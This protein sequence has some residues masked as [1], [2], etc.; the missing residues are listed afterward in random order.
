[1]NTK[2][3]LTWRWR[4]MVR[5][6]QE[7]PA[8]VDA[9]LVVGPA[10]LA[11]LSVGLVSAVVSSTLLS[12][13]SFGMVAAL[14]LRRSRPVLS[15]VVVFGLAFVH[16]VAGARLLPAD[17]AVLVALYS[18]A[19]HAPRWARQ[20]S[21]GAGLVGAALQGLNVVLNRAVSGDQAT[22]SL[23]GSVISIVIGIAALVLVAWTAGQWRRTRVAYVGSLVERARQAEAEREQQLRYAAVAERARIAR[24]MHD[25][26]AHSLSVIISQADGGRYAAAKSP[27]AAVQ[28]LETVATTGRAALRDM[29]G[30][31]GVLGDGDADVALTPQPATANVPELVAAVNASGLPVTLTITGSAQQLDSGADLAIYR[32]VQEALTN[33]LK[34]AGPR[35]S[36]QVRLNWSPA[37]LEVMVDDD[38]T[39]QAPGL[40]GGPGRGL[41]GVRQRLAAYG[42]SVQA[43]PLAGR[44]YGVRATLPLPS[45]P[46]LAERR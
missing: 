13:V 35:A 33:T 27:A 23:T 17:V 34:H 43:G 4:D 21:L 19:A 20:L 37:E 8:V 16:Y 10:V 9:A 41:I 11:V 22:T 25:I 26:V 14:A 15:V 44:G 18:A 32:T 45:A 1:M 36:A 2:A 5:W 12:V 39:S 38:G 42:G 46:K 24:E 40:N 29:R 30:L 6:G 31:L 3:S 28:A 7:H